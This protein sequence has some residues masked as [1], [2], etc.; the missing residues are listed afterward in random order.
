MERHR[1]LLTVASL[2][3]RVRV[4]GHED[5]QPTALINRS[6]EAL[7]LGRHRD[8]RRGKNT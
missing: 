4:S 3:P 2:A 8:F 1:R 5:G 6:E 7:H